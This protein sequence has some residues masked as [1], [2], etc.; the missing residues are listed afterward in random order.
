MEC[1][2]VVSDVAEDA[3]C[4]RTV[5]ECFSYDKN[6]Q[7]YVLP[8]NQKVVWL[9]PPWHMECQ[10]VVSDVA[11]DTTCH[12]A[13]SECFSYDRMTRSMSCQEIRRRYG[14]YQSL[15]HLVEKSQK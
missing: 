14:W 6:D 5:S 2:G 10:G 15:N 3:T 8:G 1:P 13:V 9:V 7:V 11:V 4:H 12:C